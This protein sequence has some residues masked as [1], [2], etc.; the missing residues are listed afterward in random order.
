MKIKGNIIKSRIAF[1]KERFGEA[2]WEKVLA[3]LPEDD[4][5]QL[6]VPTNVGWYEFEL[7]DRLD[8]AIVAVLGNGD[9][10]IFREMGRASARENLGGVHSSFLNPRDPMKFMAKAPVI[11]RFYYATGERKWESTGPSSGLLT[12]SG[13]DTF[14]TADCATVMGWYEEAL[15]MLGAQDIAVVEE[16]C[17]ARGGDACRY[18]VTWH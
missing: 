2:A 8:K 1:V 18:R 10:Q 7:G 17:C 14:S 13:S 4:R 15:S 9:T 11:Y 3:A 6:M 16:T 12:T 5:R